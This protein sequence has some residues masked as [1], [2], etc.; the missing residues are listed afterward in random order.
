[1]TGGYLRR[2]PDVVMAEVDG[3]PMLLSLRRWTYLSFNEVG[4]RVWAL[5][6]EPRDEQ[7][8]VSAL[9]AEFDGDPAEIRA[10]VGAFV[11]KLHA[12]GFLIRD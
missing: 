4:E 3:K 7:G 6:A 5:L 2:D 8:L 10:D 9:V 12:D 11:E 1:M